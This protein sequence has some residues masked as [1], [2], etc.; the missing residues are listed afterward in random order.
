MNPKLVLVGCIL[1]TMGISSYVIIDIYGEK[2]SPG[3]FTRP[4]MTHEEQLL[5]ILYFFSPGIIVLSIPFIIRGFWIH[6][7]ALIVMIPLFGVLFILVP[8]TVSILRAI[9]IIGLS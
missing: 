9:S 6:R 3:G 4:D 8:V 5:Q 2:E 7:T 1:F